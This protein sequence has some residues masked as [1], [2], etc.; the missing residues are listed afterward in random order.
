MDPPREGFSIKQPSKRDRDR[1]RLSVRESQPSGESSSTLTFDEETKGIPEPTRP[2]THGRR[3][4]MFDWVGTITQAMVVTVGPS[5][6]S[7]IGRLEAAQMMKTARRLGAQEFQ[8][9]TDP[10]EAEEWIRNTKRIFGVI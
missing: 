2:S 7:H 10:I 3:S 5:S 1:P 6:S 4:S 8:G 9:T